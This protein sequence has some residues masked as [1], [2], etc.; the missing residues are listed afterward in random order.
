MRGERA[1]P[2]TEMAIAVHGPLITESASPASKLNHH[3][4][5]PLQFS[6]TDLFW[7]LIPISKSQ[8]LQERKQSARTRPHHKMIR[9]RSR[10]Q[11]HPDQATASAN[12][13]QSTTSSQTR[14]QTSKKQPF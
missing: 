13:T 8:C 3:L 14:G 1:S 5:P 12:Q 4:R 10:A 11:T 2:A 9:R 7:S 6:P